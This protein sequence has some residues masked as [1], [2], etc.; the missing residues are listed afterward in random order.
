MRK[1]L[2]IFLLFASP[3]FA[4]ELVRY[5]TFELNTDFPNL[6]TTNPDFSDW[7]GGDPVGYTVTVNGDGDVSEVG[8][9]L[10]NGGGGTGAAN[11][12][13]SA[14]ANSGQFN[15]ANFLDAT[16]QYNIDIDYW[17]N[18]GS[19]DT[20]F[21]FASGGDTIATLNA[22]A[23]WAVEGTTGAQAE[24]LGWIRANPGN[25]MD[26][27]YDNIFV[28]ALGVTGWL[29]V[30]EWNLTNDAD[31]V[32]E[33]LANGTNNVLRQAIAGSAENDVFRCRFTV[34]GI[35]F[36]ADTFLNVTMDQADGLQPGARIINDGSYDIYVKAGASGTGI[37][38]Q[39]INGDTGDTMT[40]E[41]VSLVDPTIT[42]D[43]IVTYGPGVVQNGLA[44][45]DIGPVGVYSRTGTHNS[46]DYYKSDITHPDGA[47]GVTNWFIWWDNVDSWITSTVLGTN[48]TNYWKR[49]NAEPAGDYT[50]Q[51]NAAG[52]ITAE[53]GD[54]VATNRRRRYKGRR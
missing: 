33:A 23:H 46:K 49:T 25:T 9:G 22:S 30:D 16:T 11:L 10:F 13:H 34:S 32:W 2:L 53:A 44:N 6:L 3:L 48:G 38:F 36:D 39:V 45:E 24:K 31:A 42:T 14:P 50:N 54:E 5:G 15:T 52:T 27:T 29:W 12:F 35:T 4:Q 18:V 51:G 41:S 7:S 21:Q 47:G 19:D 17:Q 37:I 1:L 26:A 43:Q 8:Q 20:D 28:R 40:L